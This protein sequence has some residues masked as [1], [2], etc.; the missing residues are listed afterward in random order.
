MRRW[1]PLAFLAG[2]LV[3]PST[4]SAQLDL[5]AQVNWAEDADLGIGG[6]ASLRLPILA[7][8]FEVIG[9]FDLFFPDE[10]GLDYWEI[11]ANVLHAIPLKGAPLAVYVGTGLNVAYTSDDTDLSD[12]SDTQV[13]LNILGGLRW[14]G[15]PVTPFAEV[16]WELEGGEQFV[17]TGGAMFNVGPGL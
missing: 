4:A 6:R 17:L 13:G 9:S 11:N 14:T 12:Q 15:L 16:R 10:E 2:L 3:A 7:S 1:L 8:A 5:G